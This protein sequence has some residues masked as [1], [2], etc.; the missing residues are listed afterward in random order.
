VRVLVTGG[1]GF[2]GSHVAQQL[3]EQGHDVRILDAVHPLAHPIAPPGVEGAEV[4]VGDVRDRGVVD[5]ALR[6]VDAVSHQAAMVGLGVRFDDIAGYVGHND[7]GTAILLESV[8]RTNVRRLVLASSCVIYGE[9]PGRCPEHGLTPA[10]PRRPADLEAR[11]FDPRCSVCTRPL[12]PEPL[13]ETAPA[14]P[15]NVYAATKLHQE[16]LCQALVRE[17]GVPVVA[18]RY[19]NVYGAGMPRDTPYAGV[20]AIFRSALERGEPPQ[21]FEDGHQLR[22]FIHVTDIARAN[23]L[24]LEADLEGFQ[25]FNVAT[26]APRS[27]GEMAHELARAIRPD[28][29]PVVTGEFRLGDVRHVM[30]SPSRIRAELGFGSLVSFELGMRE[31]AS[32]PLRAAS[33]AE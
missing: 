29:S 11:R 28:L 33:S 9:S 12:T 16:H 10:P 4:V 23:L 21:V 25:A 7:L 17:C 19:H 22:D 20:A 15:R 27:V 24:A 13:A 1:L 8:A 5:S 14:D 26:G 18:L 2:I 6:G 31:L 30:C 32:T 3:V